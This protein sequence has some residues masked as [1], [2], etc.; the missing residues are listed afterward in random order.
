MATLILTDRG[1]DLDRIPDDWNVVEVRRATDTEGPRI[2]I[3]GPGKRFVQFLGGI[4]CDIAVVAER[5]VTETWWE[6]AR[7]TSGSERAI[8]AAHARE[9][10]AWMDQK[11]AARMAAAQAA[12]GA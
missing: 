6:M 7:T 4:D 3:E 11:D 10:Q 5:A 9:M 12:E 8:Y 1:L 2:R